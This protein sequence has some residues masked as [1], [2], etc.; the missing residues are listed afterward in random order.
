MKKKGDALCG[1]ESA[2]VSKSGQRVERDKGKGMEE[3]VAESELRQ[4]AK[5]C[6]ARVG[7]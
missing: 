5:F 4:E 1:L 7:R 2:R 3:V 6:C